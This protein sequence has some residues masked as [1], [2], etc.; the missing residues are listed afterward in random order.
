M[1]MSARLLAMPTLTWLGSVL[2]GSS[3]L[4]G[5]SSVCLFPWWAKPDESGSV[6]G[7]EEERARVEN[8]AQIT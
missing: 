1:V 5:V 4:C 3:W 8:K 6:S 2:L 7:Q